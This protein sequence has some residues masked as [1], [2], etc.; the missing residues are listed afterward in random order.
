MQDVTVAAVNFRADFGDTAGNLCHIE[1]WVRRLAQRGAEIIC[2]PELSISGYDHTPAVRSLAQPIPGP[3]TDHLVQLAARHEVTVLAGLAERD[4]GGR[5]FVT[6]AVATPGGLSGSYR[7][8][9]L[10]PAEA[11][12]F[13]PGD[14]VGVFHHDGCT[15]GLQLCYDAHFPEVSTVQALAGADL[16]FMAF[17]SPRDAAHAKA[18]R[19]MRYLPARAYDNG[20]Y[21]VACNLVGDGPAGQSF[22]GVALILG[23]KGEVLDQVAG[24]EEGAVCLQLDGAAVERLRRTRMGYFLAHR[25]P[26]LYAALTEK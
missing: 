12:V 16:L 18:E 24:E 13:Q 8:T 1:E 21:V 14:R 23:P 4:E 26:E 11:R 6:H 5:M 3:A 22:S 9:H 17:A 15:F 20:C 19:L 7:K 25:R 2:F 10:G